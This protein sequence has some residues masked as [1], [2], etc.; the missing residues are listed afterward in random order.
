MSSLFV[1]EMVVAD[2]QIP[3]GNSDEIGRI[4][5]IIL[6]A[7]FHVLVKIADRDRLGHQLMCGKV[8]KVKVVFKINKK[9]LLLILS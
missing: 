5:D 6:Q 4:M 7:V 3:K 1:Q 2:T 9:R 8:K